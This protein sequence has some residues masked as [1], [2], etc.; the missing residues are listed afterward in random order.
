MESDGGKAQF[1]LNNL[2]ESAD[3]YSYVH[4]VID[5]LV[6]TSSIQ[7]NVPLHGGLLD[8]CSTLNLFSD[9][10][11]LHNLHWVLKGVRVRCNAGIMTMNWVGKYGTF[12]EPV[13]LLEHC[14]VNIL[15]FQLVANLV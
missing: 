15:S 9:K 6:T 7:D 10:D 4:P 12:P 2:E 3:Y 5:H 1:L 11:L 13:W 8:S 14:V